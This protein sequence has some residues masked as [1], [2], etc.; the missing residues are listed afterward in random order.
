MA[1]NS[2]ILT[3]CCYV[4]FL[5]SWLQLTTCLPSPT[6][7]HP[8]MSIRKKHGSELITRSSPDDLEFSDTSHGEVTNTDQQVV[9]IN[10]G[11][12]AVSSIRRSF[13]IPF[14]PHVSS[15]P[16]S[17]Y[18]GSGS[19]SDNS[20]DVGPEYRP[21]GG[22]GFARR[23]GPGS[24]D[25][26][27]PFDAEP[28]PGD[29]PSSDHRNHMSY[30]NNFASDADDKATDRSSQTPPRVS[31]D[32]ALIPVPQLHPPPPI[33]LPV[34]PTSYGNRNG[35]T[36]SSHNTNINHNNHHNSPV[37]H[38][39]AEQ[40]Q[41]Y[42]LIPTPRPFQPPNP[43]S[44]GVSDVNSNHNH[45]NQANNNNNVFPNNYNNI[46]PLLNAFA[47]INNGFPTGINPPD[48]FSLF[49]APFS[50]IG[51][52]GAS[53]NPSNDNM[54]QRRRL[55]VQNHPNNNNEISHNSLSPVGYPNYNYY[56]GDEGDGSHSPGSGNPMRWPKI[57][58]FTDGRINLFDFEK[59]KKIGRIKFAPEDPLFDGVRRD[60][61]LILHGGTYSR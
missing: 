29:G 14:N 32:P 11:G 6:S 59:D 16:R 7:H 9:Y 42:N 1:G 37:N 55:S 50:P 15:Y 8:G 56:A 43:I 60:S 25:Q 48:F 22:E 10:H 49:D 33:G 39:P 21:E 27:T 52:P 45:N 31:H 54:F 4:L 5:I 46:N 20:A 17:L 2:V 35:V 53:S 36:T 41:R 58:K 19:Q 18:E 40:D 51:S 61:F 44:G 28:Y 34:P 24:M 23:A 26:D 13:A 47:P 38:Q 57:F 12:G 3:Q 30:S